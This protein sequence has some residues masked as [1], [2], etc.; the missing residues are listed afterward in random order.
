MA[1]TTNNYDKRT[2]NGYFGHLEITNDNEYQA[3]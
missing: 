2:N 3:H 1:V